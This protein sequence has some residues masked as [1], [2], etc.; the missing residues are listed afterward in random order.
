MTDNLP[1]VVR[2]PDLLA[3]PEVAR[4]LLSRVPAGIPVRLRGGDD[5][6]PTPAFADAFMQAAAAA[7]VPSVTVQQDTREGWLQAAHRHHISLA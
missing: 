6:I 7:R 3:E 4:A 1:A 5:V 2:L